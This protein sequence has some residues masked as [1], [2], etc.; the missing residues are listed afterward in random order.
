M[1]IERFEDIKAWQEAKELTVEV[2]RITNSGEFARDFGLRDQ[3][4]RAAV[5]IMANIAEGFGRDGTKEF[6]RFL[7]IAKASTYEVQSHL[8]V[9]VSL[10]YI[11][12]SQ[13]DD[14]YAHCLSVSRIMGGFINYLSQLAG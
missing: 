5:S 3:I 13:F 6:I 14:T 12:Q 8:H 9:A 11:S 10:H 2:Y 4:R 7:Q 1:R